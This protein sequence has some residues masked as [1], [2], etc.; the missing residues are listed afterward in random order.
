MNLFLI[1]ITKSEES[2]NFV[3]NLLQSQNPE[4]NKLGVFS[5]RKFSSKNA[6]DEKKYH[7]DEKIIKTLVQMCMKSDNKNILVN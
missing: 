5:L 7:I 4:Y 6:E 2:V 3:M 1:L